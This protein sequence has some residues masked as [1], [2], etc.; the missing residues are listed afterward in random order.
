MPP[1]DD[2]RPDPSDLLGRIK[3]QEAQ[4]RRGRLKIFLGMAAGVGKTYAMLSQAKRLRE[5]G[6][7][8]VLGVIETHG[9][10]ETDPLTAG[11]EQIPPKSF[12]NDHKTL[13]DF[14]IDRVLARKPALV[15]IDELAHTNPPGARHPKRY[16]DVLEILEAG[17]DVYTALN[18]QHLESRAG[19]VKSIS[20]IDISETVPDT[21]LDRAQEIEL[22]DVDPERLRQRIREGKVYPPDRAERALAHFFQSS[23]LTALRE[24]S[25][26]VTAERVDTDLQ[27]FR[28]EKRVTSPWK[29]S[30]R[31]LVAIA[32]SPT[33]AELIRWTRRT[34]HNLEA[35][36]IAL[37]VDSGKALDPAD[38]ALL[39]KNIALAQELGAEIIS[40]SD[41]DVT[42][43]ILRVA[44][45]RN[46]TQIVIGKPVTG[47]LRS[48]FGERTPLERLLRE[49]GDIDVLVVS[50]GKGKGLH[51]PKLLK[52]QVHSARSEYFTAMG[53]VFLTVGLG[54]AVNDMLGYRAVGLL[55]LLGVIAASLSVGRG[56][57]LLAALSGSLLWDVLFVPPRFT[58]S[59]SLSED[60]ILLCAFL[61][62]GV[63]SGTL[64]TRLRSR[65]RAYRRREER[66]S[67][68]LEFAETL[69]ST[70]NPEDLIARGLVAMERMTDA[71]I[72]LFMGTQGHLL[73]TP[74]PASTW[75]P[76]AKEVTV[77]KWVY[78]E[79]K[80]AGRGTETLTQSSGVHF[81]LSAR[82]HV[83][84]VLGL[85]IE[86]AE[87][88]SPEQ[89]SLVETL[90]GIFAITLDRE[91][92]LS[93][94]ARAEALERSQSLQKSLLN[95][96]SHELK[97]PLTAIMTAQTALREPSIVASESARSNVVQ[98]IGRAASRL[99]R[100]IENLLDM[101][102]LES[103]SLAPR[104]EIIDVGDAV[105]HALRNLREDGRQLQ[106]S[107]EI[108][109]DL[110]PVHADFGLLSQAI[111]NILH[112]ALSHNSPDVQVNIAAR[113]RDD[114]VE[115]TLTDNGKGFDAETQ[116]H[117][118]E[119][120]FRAADAR[121]GGTGLGLS[122][123]KGLIEAMG[124]HIG[125]R[126]RGIG[127]GAQFEIT[128][129]AAEESV[130]DT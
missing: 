5:G 9:R 39:D 49:S 71:K 48:I 91:S 69:A 8:V 80:R 14:D 86:T 57:M 93:E 22:I 18:V 24:I 28:T 102:R 114:Q 34:A 119:K 113:P 78:A 42:R 70:D 1:V 79:N 117:L 55:I 94:R 128:L 129:P 116:A 73:E 99:R 7:D 4:S 97:T 101:S 125:A 108:P 16:Q 109:A 126:N 88:M 130:H 105:S 75:A 32:A 30:E 31:L 21:L 59:I 67:A 15:L 112:N 122:I 53:V 20:G 107:I 33:S 11:F 58:L 98:E 111:F 115:L 61:A 26:R 23:T 10:A 66:A 100:V 123:A 121:P 12:A 63:V 64:T 47:Y 36:W 104:Q 19:V 56:P 124:G 90:A 77:A 103:G 106:V 110:P 43:A 38:Q 46:T 96:I 92:L 84:G 120:F 65:E 37:Y 27:A 2:S 41:V 40:T 68:L 29:S 127:T 35:P 6:L 76:E 44:R 81:P 82:D 3:K 50:G 51:L 60:F 72:A 52:S 89:M 45:Q 118:F 25:L 87:R 62:V 85:K 54:L 17:I 13:L 83:L 95:S 74:H